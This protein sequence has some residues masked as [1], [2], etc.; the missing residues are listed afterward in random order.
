MSAP[1]PLKRRSAVD[2]VLTEL[3]RAIVHGALR[4]GQE[5]VATQLAADM[6]VSHIPV[7]E[8]LRVLANEGLI[9]LRSQR[10]A[11]VAPIDIGNLRDTYRL[12]ILVEGDL[13][14][15]AAPL[16]T[17]EDLTRI[18]ELFGGIGS[19][20]SEADLDVHGQ[21]HRALVLP[22]AS[23][24]DLRVLQMLWVASERYLRLLFANFAPGDAQH[25]H[26]QL[27]EAASRRDGPA[28]REALS[29]HLNRGIE[30]LQAA[31]A[32]Q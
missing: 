10:K 17:D 7:R 28:L 30:I 13:I 11:L 32:E 29:G 6:D 21:F 27:L 8:A 4:P 16:Y 31:R 9:S 22:A 19:D 26:D 18:N 14:E 20:D 15:R 3:R 2:L 5:V 24:W 25:E 1:R 12:R 23:E